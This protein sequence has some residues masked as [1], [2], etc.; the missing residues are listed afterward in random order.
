MREADS[1][2]RIGGDEFV[3]VLPHLRRESDAKMLASRIRDALRLPMKIAGRSV[4][5]TASIGIAIYPD[6]A[7]TTDELLS[8][9]DTAMYSAKRGGKNQYELYTLPVTSS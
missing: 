8:H 2:I 5:V 4:S 6:S 7:I 1:V 3:V 9:A